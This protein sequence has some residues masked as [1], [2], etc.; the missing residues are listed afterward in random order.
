MTTGIL[1]GNN[2]Q[3]IC[4]SMLFTF[5]KVVKKKKKITEHA[6]TPKYFMLKVIRGIK[7]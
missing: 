2:R 4:N 5:L 6:V 3:I 1:K 7:I